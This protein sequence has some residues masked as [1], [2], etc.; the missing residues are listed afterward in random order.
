MDDVE[1]RRFKRS[2]EQVVRT[3]SQR[4]SEGFAPWRDA[5]KVDATIKGWVDSALEHR[6]TEGRVLM[7]AVHG[8][9]VVGFVSVEAQDHYI[10]GACELT[11]TKVLSM[12]RRRHP[13]RIVSAPVRR[14][15]IAARSTCSRP[16]DVSDGS[17]VATCSASP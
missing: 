14:S 10:D 7:V 5:A 3:L 17:A 12:E 1:I 6:D 2:D 8:D 13:W 16:N 4:L 9:E 15:A 11:S